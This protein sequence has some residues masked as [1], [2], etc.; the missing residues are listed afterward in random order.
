MGVI[1]RAFVTAAAISALLVSIAVPSTSAAET[2]KTE[3]HAKMFGA[4]PSVQDISLSPDGTKIAFISPGPGTTIELYTIDLTADSSP[5]RVTS[6][7]GEPENLTWC[8]W[9]SN[10]RLACKIRGLEEYLGE[11][12]EVSLVFALNADGGNQK[13][14][15]K[16]RAGNA[17]GVSLNGGDIIDWLPQEDNVVLMTRRHLEE[18]KTGSLI[19]NSAR[20]LAVDRIDTIT[21]KAKTVARPDDEAVEYIT[22]GMG[23]VRVKGKRIQKGATELDSGKIKYQFSTGNKWDTLGELDYANRIGFN[24]YAV[25][26]KSNRVFGFAPHEGRKALIAIT[27]DKDLDRQLIFAHDEVDVDALIRIGK[28]QRVVG[29]SY[30]TEKRRGIYFDPELE[31][32]ASALGKALGSGYS[33]QFADASLDESKLLIWAGSDVD[34]G[35]YFLFDK[36]SY[37]LRPLLRVRPSVENANL[38]QVRPISFPASDGTMIPGY[39]TLPV[40][41][42]GKNIPAIVMPHGGPESRD[43]WGFDWL[44]QF[45]VSQGF[46]VVQ[47]NFR[48]S[49]GYGDVWYEKNG[50]QSWRTSVGDVTDAGRWLISEGIAKPEALSIVGWSYGGYAAL[51]SAVVAPDLFKAVV[52]I[53]PV[54]DLSTLKE[55]ARNNYNRAVVRDYV[56]SGPHISEG[57]PARNVDKIKA[58]VLMFHGNFD[59]NVDV[60]HSRMMKDRLED[61]GKQVT[62]Y[63]YE[64]LAHSLRNAAVRSEILSKSA[65]FLPK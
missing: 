30:A 56:G 13:V 8:R 31:K 6:T 38:A 28:A 5:L 51:Q 52:A 29:V 16:K 34:P 50:F 37:Q 48:G 60:Q 36:S 57:S 43:E 63:E 54:T 61:A 65:E 19:K 35:Q 47:P 2:N 15:T 20:G 17:I 55:N 12:Y 59:Q 24:P 23:N 46:A 9:V 26:P 53:A 11:I 7:S 27:L 4:M 32:L 18:G 58:P 33:I 40:G 1:V 3:D 39:L 45:Y 49:S 41:A 21:G 44:S 64:E 42:S 22:D 14:L 25:D 10:D 62:Y